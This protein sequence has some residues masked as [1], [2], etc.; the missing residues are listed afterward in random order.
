MESKKEAI[1]GFEP[2]M[3]SSMGSSIAKAWTTTSK[4][5]KR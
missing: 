3:A 1:D 2:S 4:E 5:N